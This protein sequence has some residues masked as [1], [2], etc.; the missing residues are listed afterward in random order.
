MGV[1]RETS[2]AWLKGTQTTNEKTWKVFEFPN[3]I[4]A[5][6]GKISQCMRVEEISGGRIL[7]SGAAGHSGK[8]PSRIRCD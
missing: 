2:Q 6:D 1:N 7:H 8:M 5:S 4:G 3:A